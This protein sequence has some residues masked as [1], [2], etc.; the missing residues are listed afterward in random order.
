M[1]IHFDSKFAV[2]ISYINNGIKLV[3][4]RACIV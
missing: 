4:V 1:I 2:H 3:V